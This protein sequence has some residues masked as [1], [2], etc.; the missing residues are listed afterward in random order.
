MPRSVP[1]I[2]PDEHIR[3]VDELSARIANRCERRPRVGIILGTGLGSFARQIEV[4]VALAYADLPHLP[5]STAIGHK[6]QLTCG[7]VAGVSVIA[8]EGRFHVY[9]GYPS[10]Q[11]TLPI[12]V[13]HRLGIELLIISNAAGGL[14][15]HYEVGDV[16]AIEDHI[17]L[18]GANPL[19]GRTN[20]ALGKR[21][22]DM[23]RP[24][25]DALISRA[26]EIARQHDFDCHRGVYVALSGPNYET[27]AEYRFLRQMGGDVVGMSTVPEVIVANQLGLPVLAVSTVTNVCLPDALGETDGAQV[28]AAATQAE[29]KLRLI[30]LGILAEMATEPAPPEH[31]SSDRP[32]SGGRQSS[33]Q[34]VAVTTQ[35]GR[36]EQP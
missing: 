23:S 8:M 11:I 1:T 17:N 28:V 4:D 2:D 31:T 7:T 14:N 5:R 34:S 24:Y 36:G 35:S 27:R 6:G 18:M 29:R 12:R 21:F 26:R 20:D 13:M 25:D 16:M 32:A 30:V 15:P 33:D 10:W 9:E 22:P 3:A 19:I